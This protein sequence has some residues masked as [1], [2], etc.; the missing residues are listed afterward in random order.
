MKANTR[1][2]VALAA[3]DITAGQ[4][5]TRL[6]VT[7]GAVSQRMTAD[8]WTDGGACGLLAV[9]RELG[10]EHEL[11]RDG[12]RAFWAWLGQWG[13]HH[14]AHDP[15]TCPCCVQAAGGL[16]AG[17]RAAQTCKDLTSELRRA[18]RA[19]EH[20][21]REGMG[22]GEAAEHLAWQYHEACES[23]QALLEIV[24]RD[25]ERV[26]HQQA[27]HEQEMAQ[28]GRARAMMAALCRDLGVP[29][30]ADATRG[31]RDEMHRRKALLRR[32]LDWWGQGD[33]GRS[34]FADLCRFFGVPVDEPIYAQPGLTAPTGD[35]EPCVSGDLKSGRAG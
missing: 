30:Y 27:L 21:D 8:D 6:G 25:N 26:A 19:L 2:R 24:R 17:R 15:L 33:V 7:P 32:C 14:P 28:N 10:V 20:E 5:A 18:E 12:G 1:V 35:A 31:I 29:I 9:A 34:V 11:L 23:E 13:A 16:A 22:V 3:L 4:L